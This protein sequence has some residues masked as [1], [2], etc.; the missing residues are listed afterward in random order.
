M[1]PILFQFGS[2]TV[3]TYGFFIAVG[4]V[5]GALF[6]WRQGKKRYGM[7]LDQA[8]TLFL[9]LI[10]AGVIGGKLFV[11]FESPSY[12]LT[13]WSELFSKNGFV[14]YGSLL[15]TI[16]VMLWYF[17]KN[18]LPVAGMLDVM[19]A[20]TCIVHGFGR[21]GCFN[22]GCCYGKPAQGFSTVTFTNPNCQ[23]PLNV[24]L[25]PTQLYE[26]A[27]I[28]LILITLL[29]I[30]IRKKFDGQIF[31]IYLILYAV[32]RSI[33][34]LF[35]GDLERGFIIDG[36]LSISQFISALVVVAAIYFYVK[37]NRKGNFQI[38]NNNLH[39]K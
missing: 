11:V 30:D 14:F 9:L 1:H 5:L 29:I 28:F 7:S 21:I 20:V 19:A 17:K 3:Y 32:V 36:V 25:H 8:N 23:A 33:I 37:L 18:S 10:S 27:A 31:L 15:T 35:R 16:P 2:F 22:A 34:E 26:A 12:Y 38:P 13:H 39:G 6:M 4:A 24:A